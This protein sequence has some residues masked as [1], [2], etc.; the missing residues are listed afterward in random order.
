MKSCLA[1][2]IKNEISTMIRNV[3]IHTHNIDEK[4]KF[5]R[6]LIQSVYVKK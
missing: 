1:K 4:T 3:L 6:Q 2:L 5:H